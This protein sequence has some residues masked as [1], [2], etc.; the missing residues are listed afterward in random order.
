VP[1]IVNGVYILDVLPSSTKENIKKV[2]AHSSK[3]CLQLHN[4]L[5]KGQSLSQDLTGAIPK[6][7][8]THS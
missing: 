5:P 3:K 8:S 1:S 2:D 7:C 6:L 4:I